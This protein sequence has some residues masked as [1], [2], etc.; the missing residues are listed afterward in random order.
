[1]SQRSWSKLG[2]IN[3]EVKKQKEDAI[4]KSRTYQEISIN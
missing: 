3:Q 4:G 2:G 1:L